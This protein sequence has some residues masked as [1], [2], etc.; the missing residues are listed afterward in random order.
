MAIIQMKKLCVVTPKGTG[1]EVLRVLYDFGCVEITKGESAISAYEDILRFNP[2]DSDASEKS[3]A[4]FRAL[5]ALNNLTDY[6]KGL[7]SAKPT[8]GIKAFLDGSIVSEALTTAED[9]NKSLSLIDDAKTEIAA[10]T[11]DLDFYTPW[12]G[13]DLP[14]DFDSPSVAAIFGALPERV[15]VEDLKAAVNEAAPESILEV[16]STGKNVH[17]IAVLCYKPAMPK[18]LEA[19]SSLG[20]YAV[21][22]AGKTGAPAE[23]VASIQGR[24]DKAQEVIKD[25]TEHIQSLAERREVLERGYD[26]AM[27]NAAKDDLLSNIGTT[28]YTEV[29]TGWFCAEEEAPITQAL[30]AIDCAVFTADPE[31]G[32]DV[33][34]A[35]KNGKFAEPF[36]A[37]TQMYGLPKYDSIIDPNPVMV[38]FYVIFFGFMV[39]DTGYGILMTVLC[40]LALKAIKP[41]GTMKKMLT[42]FY[43]CGYGT[44]LAG[45][46]TGSWFGD[47]VA[48]FSSTFLGA[49]YAIPPVMFDPLSNPVMMLGVA[50]GMGLI[51]I[52]AGMAVSGYRQYKQGDLFGAIVDVG[53]W[54]CV[55]IGIGLFALGLFA[56]QILIGIGVATLLL[57]GGRE[58]K[59][60]FGKAIGGLGAIYGILGYMSDLL[61][62]SRIMAI[63]LSGAV[64]A[65]VFNSI[66]SMMADMVGQP[67]IG[68][69]LFVIIFVIGHVFNIAIGA[70]GA[71]VHTSRLQYIE[72]FSKFYREGGRPFRPL[73]YNT[74]FTQIVKED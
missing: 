67:I 52:M 45:V 42:L 55:F 69:I 58:K 57:F 49:T 39:C 36:D 20:F 62:Y 10:L 27:Q 74:K 14:L 72:Y 46:L 60:F 64:V 7:L 5:A 66:G 50:L 59:G 24:L 71:Y 32:D 31:E 51:H 34:T 48:A 68:F 15:A 40:H 33:P 63:G 12:V 11:K 29:F 53:G 13:M 21:S 47:A 6:A 17:N 54:Y 44:I 18:L 2:V 56:G 70:L 38:P 25:N 23:N 3:D 43:Y 73:G 26:A 41:T 37:I 16:V 19:L 1:R 9:I 65:Q 22:F 4:I 35:M 28:E 30:T 61:S 8:L